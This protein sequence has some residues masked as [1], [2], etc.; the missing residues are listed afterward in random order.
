MPSRWKPIVWTAA[1]TIPAITGYL[2]VRGGRHFPTDVIGGYIVG[3]AVG[4]LVPHLHRTIKQAKPL[5]LNV[6]LNSVY[7]GLAF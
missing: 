1:A 4:C 6:G 3:A 2:R 7:V 5:T